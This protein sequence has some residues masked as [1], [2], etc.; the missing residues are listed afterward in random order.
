MEPVEL[1]DEPVP[2]WDGVDVRLDESVVHLLPEAPREH[3]RRMTVTVSLCA[4]FWAMGMVIALLGTT[5]IDLAHQT[6]STVSRLAVVFATRSIGYFVCSMLS[7]VLLDR[8]RSP[9][10]GPLSPPA[11]SEVLLGGRAACCSVLRCC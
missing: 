1:V 11:C 6:N 4:A 7:G 9:W 8:I 5:L 10:C 2:L 3:Q